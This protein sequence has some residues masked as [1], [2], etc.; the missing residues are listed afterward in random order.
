VTKHWSYAVLS[1]TVE[2]WGFRLIQQE[3]RY[4][5]RETAARRWYAEEFRPVVR[6]LAQTDLIGDRTDAE[7][8]LHFAGQRY[9]LLRTHRWDDEVVQRLRSDPGD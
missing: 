2:A 7:A 1:E 8:Y 9:R 6:M 3:R 5:D 4:L